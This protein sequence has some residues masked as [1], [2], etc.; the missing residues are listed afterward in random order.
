MKLLILTLSWA[1]RRRFDEFFKK[2]REVSI[3]FGFESKEWGQIVKPVESLLALQR[4]VW[5]KIIIWSKKKLRG[6][7]EL[8]A[9]KSAWKSRF[10][11]DIRS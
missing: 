4:K 8:H 3:L 7:G 6:R 5:A 10:F 9:M 11:T 1:E 2:K